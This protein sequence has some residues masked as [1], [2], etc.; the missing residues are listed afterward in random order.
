MR[1]S[2]NQLQHT[3][4][5][6]KKHQ[7]TTETMFCLFDVNFCSWVGGFSTKVSVNFNFR[8]TLNAFV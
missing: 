8:S 1:T 6:L 7:K 5:S 3:H 4:P 2:K